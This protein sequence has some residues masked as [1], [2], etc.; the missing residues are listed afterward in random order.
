[1]FTD[2]DNYGGEFKD[3]IKNKITDLEAIKKFAENGY[4]FKKEL[5]N[6]LNYFFIK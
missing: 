1:M 2:P 6:Q 5:S 4:K 3:I